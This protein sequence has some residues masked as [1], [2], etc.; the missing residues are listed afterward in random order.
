MNIGIV[1]WSLL[2]NIGGLERN[3]CDLAAELNSRGHKVTLLCQDNVSDG[4]KAIC[5]IPEGCRLAKLKL[6]YDTSSLDEARK[7]I[8]AQ[9]FDVVGALFSW[10]SLLWFPSL[11]QGAGI[12]LVISEHGKPEWINSRWNA[13]ERHCC[14]DC[15]DLIHVLLHTFV[16]EYPKRFHDRIRVIPNAAVAPASVPPV[17][18][19]S[20]RCTI[21]SAGRLVE[22]PKQFSL[23]LKAFALLKDRYP[24][25]DVEICGDGVSMNYYRQ[26]AM[27]LGLTDRLRLPGMILDLTER[28]AAGDIFCIPSKVEGFGMVTVEAQAFGLPVVGFAACSG[29]NEIVVHEENGY[30]AEE[31]SAECLAR[32]LA[33]LM[34]DAGLR[35]RMGT[36]GRIML[37]RYAPK[38]VFDAWEAMLLEAAERKGRTRLQEF[39]AMENI[40]DPDFQGVKELLGRKHPFDRSNYLLAHEKSKNE[41]EPSPFSD[42]EI[43]GFIKKQK[44][45]GFPGYRSPL[46]EVKR[47]ARR[48]AGGF[49]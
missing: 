23:L 8:L 20:T 22:N 26:L 46:V 37:E 27:K 35:S 3:C 19:P 28:Y 36:R 32:Y 6:D 42:K 34:D 2:E 16:A 41:G 49:R 25:W 17:R 48:L 1:A 7:T 45:F 5:R 11:L 10:E 13:Y 44:K 14:L 38:R 12:P 39:E 33:K 30:L 18:S 4:K 31:M 29:V 40:S 15:A 21:I 43:A 47:L 24:D 9:Q